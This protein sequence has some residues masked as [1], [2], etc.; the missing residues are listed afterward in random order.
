M[1]NQVAFL[2]IVAGVA[3]LVA[4]P[5]RASD[6]FTWRVVSPATSGIP[7]EEIRFL[8]FGPDQKL[9]VGARWPFWQDGGVGVLNLATDV[10]TTYSNVEYPIPSEYVNDLEWSPDGNTAWLA[11]DA[12]LVKWTGG[13]FTV[14]HTANAPL[15]HNSIMN[16]DVDSLG[17][18]WATTP[19]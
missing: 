10:W 18:V 17:T 2:S 4:P 13:T 5:L 6:D 11:T 8:R 3:A 12:G 7:G 16:L 9:Y 19:T 15:K 1:R 14:Y